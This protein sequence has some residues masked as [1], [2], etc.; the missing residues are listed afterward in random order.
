MSGTVLRTEQIPASGEVQLGPANFF[1]LI[2][3][4]LAVDISFQDD[5]TSYGATAVTGGYVKG[6]VN[7]WRR[8][9]IRGTAGTTVV[10]FYGDEELREDVTD[11]RQTIAIIS[12][13]VN[14]ASSPAATPT[15]RAPVTLATGTQAA[16]FAANLSRRRIKVYSDSANPGS[17]YARTSGGANNIA[18][19]QPGVSEPFDGTYALDARNDTG[20]NCTFYLFEE[21]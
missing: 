8:G 14:I 2:S 9:T 1:F 3:A 17:C 5:G 11:F 21:T 19:L 18:E 7:G 15:N 13:T 12:G 6:K 4:T 20:G 10:F 16:L